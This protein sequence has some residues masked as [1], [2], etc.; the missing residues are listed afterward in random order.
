MGNVFAR[1]AVALT[2]C[3]LVGAG[4]AAG[5]TSWSSHES[6]DPFDDEVRVWT[7][8]RD[9]HTGMVRIGLRCDLPV[10][11]ASELML[12]FGH[13]ER[14]H[15]P[16]ETV[17]VKLRIDALPARTLTGRLFV[18]SE[19]SGFSMLAYGGEPLDADTLELVRELGRGEGGVIGFE[20]YG[21]RPW[22]VFLLGG[23]SARMNAVLKR[24]GVA[25]E[26]EMAAEARRAERKR[27][28]A[29]LLAQELASQLAEEAAA[30]QAAEAQE[31]LAAEA[32]RRL[33]EEAAAQRAEARAARLA[34][35]ADDRE[36][37]LLSR[38]AELQ[39]LARL[40]A[41]AITSKIE[42]NWRRPPSTGHVDC[43]VQVQQS[44]TGDVLDVRVERCRGSDLT[45]PVANAISRAVYASSPLPEPPD[46]D[47]FDRRLRVRF[48]PGAG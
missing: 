8:G 35:E 38:R 12:V 37:A 48:D 30:R 25:T 26:A 6:I 21:Q 1:G 4:Q 27:A 41:G 47:L 24:C 45:P 2:A 39:R 7:V 19:S 3:L 34:E 32:A 40:Y 29:E 42:S 17:A 20:V 31:R 18:D 5:A 9:D 23:A 46:P 11:E 16:G 22:H 10:G 13:D 43:T 36:R 15:E 28:E 44:I 33:A 14:L